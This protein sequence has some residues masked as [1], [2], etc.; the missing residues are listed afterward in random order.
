M[1][2]TIDALQPRSEIQISPIIVST[3]CECHDFVASHFPSST[4]NKAQGGEE[5]SSS[6]PRRLIRLHDLRRLIARPD[7]LM[8]RAV[9]HVLHV[10]VLPLRA[11]PD[12]DLASTADDTN[13]HRAQQVVRGVGVHVHASVEHGRGV[14]ANAA[15]DHGFASGVVLDEFRDVVDNARNGNEAA[16]VLG[17]VDVVVPLNNG[18]LVQGHA[19]VEP[20]ALLVQFLLLLLHAALFDLVLLELLEVESQPHLLPAPNRPFGGVV[21]VP[22]D[23]VA[24]IG[25][26]LVVKIVVTL[27]EGDKRGDDVVTG[28]VTV[29]EG[30]IAEPVR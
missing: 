13:P 7:D 30:L 24:V 8:T 19:P 1:A 3:D 5:D 22:F 25:G 18:E 10:L 4:D 27:A 26:E 2:N 16:S 29:I 6:R 9:V 15:A 17:L 11:L 20:R 21:L 12:L 28:A 14:L 23:G